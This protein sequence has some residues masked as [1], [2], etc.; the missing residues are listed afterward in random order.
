MIKK[1]EYDSVWERIVTKGWNGLQVV[2]VELSGDPDRLREMGPALVKE[3][4]K[5]RGCSAD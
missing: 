2:V 1:W 3:L 5:L 4:N